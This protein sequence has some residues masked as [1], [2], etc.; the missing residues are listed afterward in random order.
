MDVEEGSDDDDV[1]EE[2]EG[3]MQSEKDSAFG[4]GFGFGWGDSDPSFTKEEKKDEDK[5]AANISS[6]NADRKKKSKSRSARVL[7]EEKILEVMEDERDSVVPT[8]PEDFDRLLLTSPNASYLWIQ[9]MAF[10]IGRSQ[11]EGARRIA[12]R[13][14]EVMSIRE[15]EEKRNVWFAWLNLESQH[16]T[17]DSLEETFRECI[18]QND[19]RTVYS[20]M[21]DLLEKMGK[22]E[23]C[24]KL[25]AEMRKKLHTSL[26]VWSQY[27]LFLIR[28]GRMTEMRDIWFDRAIEALPLRKHIQLL[29]KAAGWECKYGT[30]ERGRS[31][32][33]QMVSRHPKRY[34]L[35]NVYL[36]TEIS[37]IQGSDDVVRIRR[38]FHRVLSLK[39]STK[40][41]KN[42]LKKFLSFEKSHG[43]EQSILDVIQIAKDYASSL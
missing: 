33:E 41:M 11:I 9:Y 30:I 8:S 28:N 35:W 12:K 4:G 5:T 20:Y 39:L 6:G 15:E 24:E 32:F 36:D 7:E 17:D 42:A 10:Y 26:K 29:I 18:Q 3:V 43:N 21:L 14:I 37:N 31:M 27:L 34:D 19:R 22:L 40:K 23:R 16:G 1:E 38:L 25:Y 2:E 13:A